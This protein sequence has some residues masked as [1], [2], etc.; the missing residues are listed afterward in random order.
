MKTYDVFYK[1]TKVTYFRVN[2]NSE[3]EARVVADNLLMKDR[4]F[5]GAYDTIIKFDKTLEG[6]VDFQKLPITEEGFPIIYRQ[7][8][9]EI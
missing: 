6:P 2:A 3:A 7:W 8:D 5:D 9:N 1:K 4:N